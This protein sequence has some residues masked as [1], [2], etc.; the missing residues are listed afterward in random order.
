MLRYFIMNAPVTFISI[1]VCVLVWVLIQ[2]KGR[3]D[4]VNK[5]ALIPWYVRQGQWYRIITVG[6]VHIQVYHLFMNMYALYN[7][8]S[9]LEPYF[10]S[11]LFAFILYASVIGGSLAVYFLGRKNV[12]TVGISGGIYGLL[13]AYIILL[14]RYGLLANASIRYSILQTL[15]VNALISLMPNV[16]MHGHLGG[17]LTGLLLGFLFIR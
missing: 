1:V 14:W 15:I 11:P 17:L 6:F 4:L 5:L 13:G 12:T 2:V 16:S 8:G 9:F 3:S 10:G 7:M